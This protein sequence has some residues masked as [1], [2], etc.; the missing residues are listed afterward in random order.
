MRS[1]AVKLAVF[2]AGLALAPI[3]APGDSDWFGEYEACRSAF[4]DQ[5]FGYVS[6]DGA[7]VRD[8]AGDRG[9]VLVKLP[10]GHHLLLPEA[11]RTGQE[12]LRVTVEVP[13]QRT[14]SRNGW[15]RRA[16]VAVRSEFR[17]VVRCWPVE[18]I[19]WRDPLNPFEA[20]G[21]ALRIDMSDTGDA[22]R[23]LGTSPA[24]RG[25]GVYYSQGLFL[26]ELDT[27]PAGDEGES[28]VDAV[29]V[30]D[31]SG[32]QV[33]LNDILHMTSLSSSV[34]RSAFRSGSYLG[35]C[36]GGPVVDPSRRIP[37]G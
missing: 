12:W 7:L 5:C 19:E 9:S 30:L 33:R 36:G 1:K 15:M 20:P 23:V 13:G 17:R 31:T 8:R 18:R 25:F 26:V 37:E 14:N 10:I 27:L 28:S 35:R 21:T 16:D 11:P 4:G 3:A 34:A 24:G 6:R 22:A 29:F 32:R 2:V